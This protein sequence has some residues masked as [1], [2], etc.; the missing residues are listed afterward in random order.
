M[1]NSIGLKEI[2]G[3]EYRINDGDWQD[4][5]IFD[6]L[7][8]DTTYTFYQRLKASADG[9]YLASAETSA[10]ATTQ[11][12]GASTITI[13]FNQKFVSKTYDRTGGFDE[14]SSGLYTINLSI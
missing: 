2:A 5:P 11:S 7:T 14:L 9:N 10:I 3:A 8:P 6:R 4:S 1:N 12:V 13:P